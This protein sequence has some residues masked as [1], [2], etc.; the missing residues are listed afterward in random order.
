MNSSYDVVIVGGGLSG[1]STAY[2]LL[3]QPDFTGSVLVVERDPTYQNAPSAKATGGIRQ[4][5]STPEN[6]QIGLFG[7][8]F[9]KSIEGRLA[10]DD[11]STGV[12]FRERGYLV[13]ATP[14]ALPVLQSNHVVQTA[15]GADIVF[16][17][18]AALNARFPWI[19]VQGLAGGFFGQ[20][21]EGWV[22]PYSLLQ[23]FRRKARALGA[24]FVADEAIGVMHNGRRVSGVELVAGGKIDAGVVV[25]TAGA[26]GARPISES[27]GVPL[28]IESRL[29]C[30]FVFECREPGIEGGPL[31]V[32]PNGTAWRPEGARFLV[33]VSPPEDR[34]PETLEHEIDHALFDDI[35]WPTLAEWIPAFEAIK[36]VQT[37][38]CHYDFNTLDENLIIGLAGDFENFYMAAGF[39]GHGMQQSPAVG[40][41]L[42]ELI[43]FGEFRS[44]DL[45]RLGYA[46]VRTGER[47]LESNCW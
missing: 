24:V 5:F 20:S 25:N 23:A 46:R 38:S 39:S 18:Q 4:Q 6:V 45:R 33:N 43:C 44:L 10:V 13:L 8:E 7:A 30:T 22:D 15:Q 1:C 17:G 40:R 36:V 32:L 29:R 26:R 14:A 34:D 11:E 12:I 16:L 21:N 28:P 19:K 47:I 27:A 42:S 3:S 35:I 31:T 37:Y 41:A 2:W 9:A